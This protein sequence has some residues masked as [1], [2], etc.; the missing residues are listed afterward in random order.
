MSEKEIKISVL[1]TEI[2]TSYALLIEAGE[3]ANLTGINFI[4]ELAGRLAS[5][6]T[7]E[8]A[9]DTLKET[10]RGVGITPCVKWSQVPSIK[11]SSKI[12]NAYEKEI[13]EIKVS[14]ILSLGRRVLADVKAG[15]VDAHIKKYSTFA[16]LDANTNTIAESQARDKGEEILAEAEALSDGITFES[17]VDGFLALI[18]K[19]DITKLTTKEIEKTH[20]LIGA[21]MQV[22]KNTKAQATA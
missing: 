3:E 15:K 14:K 2:A 16:E 17:A 7:Q 20:A 22:E 19:Q 1:D 13:S 8:I 6:L 12:I 4:T 21:L 9:Q 10:A 18:K 5:G 11:T